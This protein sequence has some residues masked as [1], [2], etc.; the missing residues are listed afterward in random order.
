MGR[1]SSAPVGRAVWA[2][3]DM[4]AAD[5]GAKLNRMCF[6]CHERNLG[7]NLVSGYLLQAISRRL[8]ILSWGTIRRR[9]L[10]QPAERECP[11]PRN[12]SGKNELVFFY[13]SAMTRVK[14]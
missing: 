7:P 1:R 9:I 2:L 5:A 13:R 4:L 14:S 8:L 6:F 11:F 12:S 10:E 3:P